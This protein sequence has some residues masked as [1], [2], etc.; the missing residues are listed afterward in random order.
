MG[1]GGSE[2]GLV[3]APTADVPFVDVPGDTNGEVGL[4]AADLDR[5]YGV[6]LDLVYDV[7]CD[8][9]EEGGKLCAAAVV[10]EVCQLVS[11]MAQQALEEWKVMGI[12]GVS[13]EGSIEWCDRMQNGGGTEAAGQLGVP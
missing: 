9:W 11:G 13:G 6:I 10:S 12:I 5:G 1:R 8:E 4:E 2:S 7:I 3:R